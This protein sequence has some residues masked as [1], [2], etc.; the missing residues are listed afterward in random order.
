MTIDR[1]E[2]NEVLSAAMSN[3]ADD[4]T[5]DQRLRFGHKLLKTY[6][7]E[8]D[9]E[10][11]EDWLAAFSN[12]DTV[13]E[14]GGDRNLASLSIGEFTAFADRIEDRFVLVHSIEGAQ[15]TGRFIDSLV[16]G[17]GLDRLWLGN[18][19]LETIAEWGTFKGFGSRFDRQVKGDIDPA[20]TESV[21]PEVEPLVEPQHS[22]TEAAELPVQSLS[23]RLAGSQ[24]R[25]LLDV[26]KEHELLRH[27]VSLSS[28]RM[29]YSDENAAVITDEVYYS[30]KLTARGDSYELHRDLVGRI[31]DSYKLRLASIEDEAALTVSDHGG[32]LG[33]TVIA[34]LNGTIDVD[35]IVTTVFSGT[36]P[37]RI[38]GIPLK[39]ADDY[40]SVRAVDLHSGSPLNFEVAPEMIR[41]YI[42]QGVCGNTLLRLETNLQQFFDAAVRL[43]L[44]TSGALI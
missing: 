19:T 44:G 43:E 7:I 2:M 32:L 12:D 23:I 9:A 40:V 13:V 3:A 31:V 5:E 28:V 15:E 10:A 25:Y 4:L 30:G 34:P 42:P 6:A 37:F 11:R 20:L 38:A 18:Q 17:R 33:S 27:S 39:L 35:S 14:P 29:R 21:E 8:L 16:A 26:L 24:S 1:R 41:A 22:P 36:K